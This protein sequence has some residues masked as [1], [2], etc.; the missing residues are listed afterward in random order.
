MRSAVI[1]LAAILLMVMLVIAAATSVLTI[2]PGGGGAPAPTA[3][4]LERIPSAY[5][6]L[7]QQAAQRCPGLPWTVLAA[8]GEVESDH[9]RSTAPGVQSGANSAGAAGPM[10]MGIGT[11]PAG[12]AFWRFAADGNADGTALPYDPADAIPTAAAYLCQALADGHGDLAGAVFAYNHDDAYVDRVL[13]LAA[14]YGT[15]IEAPTPAANQAVAFALA[16]LGT[17]YRWGGDGLEEGGFDCSGLVHAAYQAAGIRLPRTAQTQYD[18]D[19]HLPPASQLLPG[20]LVFFGTGPAN[21]THV[22]I[23]ISPGQ[24]VDAPHTGALVR[25]EP[26]TRRTY[27]GATR[28]SVPAAHP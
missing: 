1:G 18:A 11:G 8:I 9:G 10:Q 4:A 21:V 12:D 6:A 20:D 25:V 26:Y 3:Q 23:V 22:G 14:S 13:A 16:Q 19:P 17:P 28:P 7:Y 24:M 15:P 2:L 5:L 27:L